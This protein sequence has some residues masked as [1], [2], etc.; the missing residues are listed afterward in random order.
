[1]ARGG[2]AGTLS[3]TTAETIQQRLMFVGSEQ[4]KLLAIRQLIAAVR[5]G[6]LGEA[7]AEGAP[8]RLTRV[9]STATLAPFFPGMGVVARACGLRC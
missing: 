4:G 1:M 7:S 2:G 9:G 5:N 3:N 6:R 8:C